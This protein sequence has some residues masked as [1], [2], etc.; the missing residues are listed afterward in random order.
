MAEHIQPDAARRRLRSYG[1]LLHQQRRPTDYEVASSRLLWYP[2]RGFE[3]PVRQ[4]DWYDGHQG[5][6]AFQGV[7]WEQFVDP[8]T[9]TYDAYVA[10][11][12]RQELYV[13]G[14]QASLVE[15]G[16]EARLSRAWVDRLAAA[17]GPLR[18]PLHGFHMV[19]AY[20]GSMVPGSRIAIACA[21][22]GADEVRRIERLAFRLHRLT[23]QR[24]G[25][26]A[27]ARDDWERADAWQ[28][29]REAVERLLV[30]YAWDEAL[31][32]LN[33]CLKP[34][35]DT[36]T[37]L[38]FGRWAIQEGA[39]LDGEILL[40]LHANAR[41]HQEWT[42]AFLETAI[43]HDPALAQVIAGWQERW[44]PL[45]QAAVAAL[46]PLFAPDPAVV[47]AETAR[48]APVTLA[49]TLGPQAYLVQEPHP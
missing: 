4:Q 41:W 22:Q 14:L 49:A 12:S 5:G 6:A 28:P 38:V 3:I 10:E 45:A 39:H 47:Q 8:Q 16:D 34:L 13:E 26:E 9:L 32:A 15:S 46:S 35:I 33:L 31:V 7:D 48:L 44:L 36:L 2:G 25:C 17:L 1:H 21:F 19:A 42:Q 37:H 18:F 20:A 23:A 40:A 27:A 30:T 43:N 29:L 24:P 11:R